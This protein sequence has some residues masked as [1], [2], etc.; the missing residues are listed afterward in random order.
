MVHYKIKQNDTVV[1][2]VGRNRG[3]TGR[4]VKVDH[5]KG[6]VI[7]EKVN[8]VKRA[9][10]PSGDRP[11]GIVEKEAPLHVCKVALY[12]AASQSAVKV[13]FRYE[14]GVKVRYNKANG[15]AI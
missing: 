2:L 10:K 9:V 12:D 14:E 6:Q 13:G 8:L 15:Q 1:V 5:K 11:G 7:V 3:K 4:V